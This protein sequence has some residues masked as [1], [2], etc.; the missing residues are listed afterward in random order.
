M[1]TQAEDFTYGT[2]KRSR[3]A[4]ILGRE[5]LLIYHSALNLLFDGPDI[6]VTQGFIR[7]KIEKLWKDRNGYFLRDQ[8]ET[9]IEAVTEAVVSSLSSQK[10][11]VAV[12][13][14]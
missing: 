2:V 3:E 4:G 13:N 1:V 7:G 9:M 14:N 5:G 12:Y 11:A 10:K 6:E 8:E